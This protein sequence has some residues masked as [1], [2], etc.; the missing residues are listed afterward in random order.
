VKR[1]YRTAVV[2][3]LGNGAIAAYSSGVVYLHI[4]SRKSKMKMSFA[5]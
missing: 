5:E 2:F 3:F 1:E 4:S